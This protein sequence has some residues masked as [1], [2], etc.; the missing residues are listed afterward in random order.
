M[1]FQEAYE[2]IALF[3]TF[4]AGSMLPPV[5]AALSDAR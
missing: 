2:K 4:W 1:P 3:L 5:L